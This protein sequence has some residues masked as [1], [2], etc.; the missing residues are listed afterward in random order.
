MA[1]IDMSKVEEAVG[2]VMGFMTGAGVCGGIVLGDRLGLYRAL[3]GSEA[4]LPHTELALQTGTHSRLVREWLD[5][6]V[7]AGL[8]GYD[9]ARDRYDLPAEHAMI[10]ADEDSPVFLAGGMGLFQAMFAGL[11]KME[12]AFQGDGGFAWSDQHESLFPATARFFRPGY[13]THLIA[14]W[15]PALDGVADRLGKGGRIADVGCGFGHS[16][17]LMAQAYPNAQV[18]G[19]DYHQG[20]IDGARQAA[21][22]QGL[23]GRVRFERADARSFTGSFDLICFF[24]CLHDMGDPVEIARHAKAQLAPGGTILLVEPYA[25][26]TRVESHANPAAALFYN[27]STFFCTPNA[28]SQGR[29]ALGAQC[30]EAGM[31]AVFSEAGYSHF[32]RATETPFNIIYEIRA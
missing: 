6:Q 32:R 18:T 27:A 23:G 12:R 26:D 1:T 3:A 2:A 11:P 15:I 28:L 17:T 8:V 21:D 14:E 29:E 13:R 5:G 16:A 10:L 7:A 30:G 20:S 31:R 9:A 24:D 19:F 25:F 22:E 4:R